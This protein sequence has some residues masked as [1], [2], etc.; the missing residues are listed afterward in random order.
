MLI[1]LG[2]GWGSVCSIL[3]NVEGWWHQT[4]LGGGCGKYLE[5]C[6]K[7]RLSKNS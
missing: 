3:I 6:E 1:L 2:L 4:L 7:L 5:G